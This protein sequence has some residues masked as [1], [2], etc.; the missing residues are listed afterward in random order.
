M[1]VA[2]RVYIFSPF[3]TFCLLNCVAPAHSVTN[4]NQKGASDGYIKISEIATAQNQAPQ[5]WIEQLQRLDLE[6]EKR[7]RS[8][9]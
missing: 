5:Q 3:S 7:R 9:C 2:W 6:R 1:M 8:I 4:Q